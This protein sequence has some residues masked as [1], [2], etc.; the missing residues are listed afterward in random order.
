MLKSKCQAHLFLSGF[1]TITITITASHDYTFCVLSTCF[2]FKWL[3][4]NYFKRT[5]KVN[6][7]FFLL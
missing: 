6:N 3:L 1:I 5:G 7:F 2:L 4:A